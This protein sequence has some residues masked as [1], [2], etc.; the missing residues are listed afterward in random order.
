[1]SVSAPVVA[2]LAATAATAST[3]IQTQDMMQ[4]SASTGLRI[5]R[6]S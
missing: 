6:S 2:A 1:M 4:R 3:K 5:R